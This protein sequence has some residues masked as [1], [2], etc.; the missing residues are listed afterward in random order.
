MRKLSFP[1]LLILSSACLGQ[2]ADS[3]LLA[4]KRGEYFDLYRKCL[5]YDDLSGSAYALG[6]FLHFGGEAKYRDT[7]AVIY[8]RMGNLNGSYKLAG[9][10]N[11][12][13]AKNTTALA[14]LADISSRGGDHKTSLDW[15]DK[16]CQLSPGPFNFYQMATKQFILE[17]VGECKST[18]AKIVADTAKARQEEVSLEI[19][20]GQNEQVSAMAA[21]YNMLGALAFR[22]K[23]NALALKYYELALKEKPD[24]VI[25]KQNAESLKKPVSKPGTPKAKS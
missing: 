6:A 17:R 20:P 23:D 8:Y 3:A 22:D 21:A 1:V 4:G 24:F 15:Y 12:S 7:L 9:E 25:A 19:A 11:K 10:I 18:L 5:S 13:D 14:L 2:S 16:L